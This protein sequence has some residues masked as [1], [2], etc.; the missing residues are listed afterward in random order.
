PD[1]ILDPVALYGANCAGCHGADGTHGPAMALADPLY[2]SIVDDNTLRTTIADGRS[3]T[4]MSAFSQK[5][6]GTLTDEQINS[7]VQGIRARWGRAGRTNGSTAPPYAA[8]VQG[9]APQ[10]HA[11]YATF[12][13]SC[14]GRVGQP[15]SITDP[16][17]LSLVSDQGL[18]TIVIA[19]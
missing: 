10:G 17:Y 6:G 11:V 14:H 2:L 15:G 3:G 4:A 8:S 7:T 9:N 19:G 16:A 18:R 5:A 12:C 13:S 1:S